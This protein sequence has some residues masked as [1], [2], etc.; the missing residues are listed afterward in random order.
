MAPALALLGALAACSASPEAQL[1]T[2]STRPPGPSTTVTLAPATT[3]TS[4][5]PAVNATIE[6]LMEAAGMTTLGRRIFVAARP[7]LQ[8]AAG[9]AT[10]CGLDVTAEP[11]GTHTFGCLVRG[12][13]HVRSFGAPE[14][15]DLS[16]AVAAHELLHA[17]YIQLPAAER[18]RL[19]ADLATARAGN[20]RLEERLSV[21]AETADDTPNEVHSVLGSEFPDLSPALEAHYARYFDRSK[22]L[23]AYQRTLGGREDELFRLAGE[24]EELNARLEEMQAELD[25]LEASGRIS[26][27]NALIPRYNSLIREHNAAARLYNE[28]LSD[29]RRLIAA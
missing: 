23:S 2:A 10:D 1:S 14:L 6:D 8:D 7:E 27:Y 16:Y 11:G 21:Y 12:R 28:R 13:I 15:H 20:A 4:P 25:A 24:A 19:D 26:A 9:L 22:V 5:P 18:T 17:V 3:T 29:Y